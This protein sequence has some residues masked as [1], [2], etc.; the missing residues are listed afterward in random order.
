MSLLFYRNNSSKYDNIPFKVVIPG[1]PAVYQL[2]P[3]KEN[4]GT[5]TRMTLGE[6]NP[7][8]LN[9]TILLVGET[10]TGKST[11]INALVN[12]AMG[13]KWE[14]EVWFQIV[15]EEKR[16]QSRSQTSDVIVYQIFGFEDETLPYSLTIIDTPGYGDT[17]G[18]EHDD[19]ISQRLFDLFRTVDGV[20]EIDAV[21]LVMKGSENRLSDRL[22][23]IFDSVISLFGKDLEKNI[24]TLITHSD[25]VTPENV[26]EALE[27]ANIKFARDEDNDHVYFMFNNRQSTEKTKKNKVAL[28]SAW[29]LTMDQMAHFTNFMKETLPKKLETTVEELN[30]HARLTACINNLQERIELIDL[31]QKEIQQTHEALN[32]HKEEMKNKEK[33]TVE[34]DEP[35]KDK[36]PISGGQGGLFYEEAV[37]CKTCEE[38]C[39]YPGCTVALTPE[40]CEVMEDGCCTVCGCSVSAHVKEEWKYVNKTKKVKKVLKD[41]KEKFT[42]NKAGSESKLNLLETLKENMEELQ[43]EKHM[44]LDKFFQRVVKLEQIALKVDSLST[45]VPLDFLIEKMKEKGEMEKERKL[46]EMKC[47]MDERTRAA[48]RYGF[49]KLTAAGKAKC[50]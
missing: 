47:R 33:F 20:H 29:D 15:E 41:V 30:T 23:Y 45:H 21:G 25:G 14:D 2:M 50:K 28:K 4:I 22:M 8:K 17:R 3:K 7:N 9:K 19:I 35:Y 12:Y 11:L 24:V 16:R 43:K 49:D 1:S 46:E 5:L 40:S 37:C 34:V 27:D 32:K 44:L 42:K 38:N 48:S 26:L 6:K 18:I 36:E 31:K 10:G 13:V 39:H